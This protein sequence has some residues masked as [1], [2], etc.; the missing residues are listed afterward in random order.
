MVS[1][2]IAQA[3]VLERKLEP[4]EMARPFKLREGEAAESKPAALAF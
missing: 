4:K 3:H 1:S 2:M